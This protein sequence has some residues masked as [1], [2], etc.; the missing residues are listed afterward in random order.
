VTVQ[1]NN[2]IKKGFE[3]VITRDGDRY[4]L[5][6]TVAVQPFEDWGTRD[7]GR[8]ERDDVSGMLPPK[9]AR[10]MLNISGADPEGAL[11]DP[12]CGSG[13][14]ISEAIA[15]GFNN[16]TGTDISEK[17]VEDTKKNIEWLMKKMPDTGAKIKI[18][19]A[20]AN[21][22]SKKLTA[23]SIDAIVSEPYL[24]QPLKGRETRAELAKQ[25][26]ELKLM[27]ISALKELNK[28]LKN[29]GMVVF[30]L[31]K[32]R[33]ANGWLSVDLSDA[34]AKLGWRAEPVLK[35]EGREY[36][37]LLYARYNQR[38]GREIWRFRKI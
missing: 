35:I 14:I 10:M 34:V 23:N 6:R 38:V 32:F 37:S 20:D 33:L 19:V 12:F 21:D 22:L 2:L 29:N 24:G 4:S 26:D 28:I 17:A 30:I 36:F 7:F 15:L 18:F 25:A 16:I 31:P 1:K 9:L 13:T 5:A 27:Y 8:P 3:F 11:L